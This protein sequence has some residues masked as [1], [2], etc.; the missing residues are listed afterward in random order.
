MKIK[1]KD[2]NGNEEILFDNSHYLA[3][4]IAITIIGMFFGLWAFG[5]YGILLLF[6]FVFLFNWDWNEKI[7]FDNG[8]KTIIMEEKIIAGR[9]FKW[10]EA[11]KIKFSDIKGIY[12]I[13][14]EHEKFYDTGVSFRNYNTELIIDKESAIKLPSKNDSKG[15]KEFAIK[16]CKATGING[17]YIDEKKNSTVLS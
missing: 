4:S 12:V 11:N 9:E 15:A 7:I 6:L 17:Y 5:I 3:I 13:E 8:I 1:I 16:I 14:D 2:E 10:K